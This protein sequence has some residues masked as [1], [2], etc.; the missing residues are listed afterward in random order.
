MKKIISICA[1]LVLAFS[2]SACGNQTL[3]DTTYTFDRVQIRM[4]DGSVVEGEVESWTDFESSDML[5]VKV[6]GK[7]YLTY[8]SNVVLID[9]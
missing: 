1:G 5:Q 3:F 4:M 9:E 6:D 8:S 2:M 7:T